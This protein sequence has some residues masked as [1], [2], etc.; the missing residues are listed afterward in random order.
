MHFRI[1]LPKCGT[2]YRCILK[3]ILNFLANIFSW[4]L[5]IDNKPRAAQVMD[6]YDVT[7]SHYFLTNIAS[8]GLS[9]LSFNNADYNFEIILAWHLNIKRDM[10]KRFIYVG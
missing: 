6:R 4:L 9:E 3:Y 8:Q 1:G 2:A 7:G 10:T 5:S